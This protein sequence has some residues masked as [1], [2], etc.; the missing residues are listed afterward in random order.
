MGLI[1]WILSKP[2]QDATLLV[3]IARVSVLLLGVT[4]ATI[5]VFLAGKR[6]GLM[7]RQHVTDSFG[8]ALA[9]LSDRES[10]VRVGA[11]YAL[12]QIA[13]DNPRTYYLPIIDTLCAFVREYSV[14]ARYYQVRKDHPNTNHPKEIRN[15]AK[16]IAKY[17]TSPEL[18]VVPE[19]I[20]AAIQVIGRR[21][22]PRKEF[23]LFKSITV[24][25]SP[26]RLERKK[27]LNLKGVY[28]HHF[29]GS[30]EVLNFDFALFEDADFSYGDLENCRFAHASFYDAD[31]ECCKID[32]SSF[33]DADIN[34]NL[35]QNAWT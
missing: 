1:D 31:F 30:D 25:L 14:I 10:S 33:S 6:Y 13:N 3:D 24:D 2:P 18:D 5:T 8:S 15:L 32:M 28:L 12:E 26:K 7:H 16:K 35:L 29:P 4:L 22:Y 20:F 17:M 19:D 27:R 21:K 9:K 23:S 34:P 11:I